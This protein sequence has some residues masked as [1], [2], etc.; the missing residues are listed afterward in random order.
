MKT[1]GL[2][3]AVLFGLLLGVPHLARADDQPGANAIDK[4]KEMLAV[5]QQ[6]KAM[7]AMLGPVSQTMEDL[8]ERANPG[9]EK[10]VRDFMLKYYIPEV[11]ERLPELSDLLAEEWARY[12]TAE[13]IDRLIAFY[14][15]DV[16]QKLIVL[17]PKLMQDA[18]QLGGA[19][20]QRVAREVFRKVQPALEKQGLKSPNI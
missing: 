1:R 6:V 8:I 9:R 17:Q 12:F 4:A 15:S 16:G 2:P 20:G 14:R 3:V 11:R 18:F 5:T 19:W 7:D 13:E 10:E